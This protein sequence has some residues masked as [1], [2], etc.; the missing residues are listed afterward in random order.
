MRGRRRY[1]WTC[2]LLRERYLA[3]TTHTVDGIGRPLESRLRERAT[4]PIWLPTWFQR[5]ETD[6]H[7]TDVVVIGAGA[8]GVAAA[9]RL[10]AGS[11]R[12]VVLEARSRIGG[13][14][15][16]LRGAG[17]PL[18]LGCGWLHS[19]DENEWAAVAV[20]L[21]LAIDRTPPPWGTRRNTIGFPPDELAEFR[22]ASE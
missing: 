6:M 18:D 10:A 21:G 12:T 19:A 14:A 3:E 1:W 15:W 7:D 2:R 20:T 8:A 11:V 4:L 5:H 16:T 9:R 22:A 13:R 17:L